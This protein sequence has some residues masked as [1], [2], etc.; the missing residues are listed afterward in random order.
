MY[1][2]PNPCR[3]RGRSLSIR[4]LLGANLVLIGAAWVLS[5]YGYARLPLRVPSWL[6]LWK[7]GRPLVERSLA[8]FIYP[9]FQVVLFLGLRALARRF[10]F[11]RPGPQA[12]TAIPPTDPEKARRILSLKKEV[13]YLALIFVNLV[14]IHP[15]SS[16]TLLSHQLVTGINTL[17]L[18]AVLVMILFILG[19]YYRIRLKILLSSQA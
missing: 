1:G 12:G 18:A 15:Q 7:G 11:R 9:V 3:L 6:A 17:Y 13:A 14:F 16:L 5:I 4:L 8:Y 19:P 10:F 2:L